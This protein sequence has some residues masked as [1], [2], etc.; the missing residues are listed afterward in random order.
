MAAILGKIEEFDRSKEEWPQYVERLGHFF[1]ANDI[2]SAEKKR[3][4]FLAVVGPTTYR[5]LHN[6]L[7]PAKPGDSSYEELVAKLTKHFNPTPSEAVQRFKFN[8]RVRK[9]GESVSTY[10]SELRS[11][12]E[13]CNYGSSLESMLRDRLMCGIQ[14]EGIQK[15]LMAEPK[16]TYAK[17]LELA[18]GLEA[19]SKSMQELGNSKEPAGESGGTT[20]I[21]H[22]VASGTQGRTN[23][24]R[25]GGANHI[26]STCRHKNTVCNGCGKRGHLK[27]VCRS[28]SKSTAPSRTGR[29]RRTPKPVHRV[30][31]SEEDNELPLFHV[32]ESDKSQ[33][34]RVTVT[35]EQ[36]EIPMEVDTGAALSLVSETTYKEL[37]LDRTL[38]QSS[39]K[40][41]SYSGEAIP[42]LGSFDVKVA[43]KSQVATL[44]LLVVKGDGPSLF[45]RNWLNH[46]RLE[47][48]EIYNFHT[49]S[50]QAT[51]QKHGA[52]FK[53]GLGTLKGFKAKI[54]VE[55]GATPR[56]SKARTVPYSLKEMVD[57]ELDRL[58][59]EG[60]LEP[61]QFSDWASPIVPVLKADKSSIRICGDFKQ[62]INPVSKLDRYPIPKIEDLFASLAGGQSFT[63]IDLSQAYQQLL[64]DDDS[65][66]YV[67]I[68]THRGLFRYTRL[69]FGVSSAP[70]I[71]QRVMESVLQG[72]PGVVVYIDDILVTGPTADKHLETLEQVLAR[73]EN[74]GLRVKQSKCKFMAPSVEY[75]GFKID[76]NG[77]HPLVE[78]VEAVRDAPTPR[79]VQELKAYLG[80]L[81]YYSKFLPNMSSVLTPLYQLLRKDAPWHWTKSQE[82]AFAESKA[83][84]VSSR[85]LVH[86]NPTLPLTLACDASA[87]GVGAVLAHRMPD[88]TERPIGYASRSLTKAERNYSQLEKEGLACIFGIKRFHSYLFGHHFELVTD[89]KPLL[90]L[91]N[92]HR[93]TSPQA[94]SRIRRWSLFLSGYEYTL[95]FRSTTEHG[96]ADALSRLPLKTVDHPSETPPEL[97][98]LMEH[99][100]DSPLTQQ[101]I[102][103]YTRRDPLL[104]QVLQYL[105]SGWPDQSDPKLKPF[106][107]R[108]E[109]L[110]LLD[111][112]ILW[113]SRVVVP[114][115]AT[116]TVLQELHEG[117][118]GMTR[119]KSL[120]RMYVWWPGMDKDIEKSVASCTQ[121][122]LHQV[123]PPVAPLNPWKWPTRPWARLHVDFAGPMQ[124]KMYLVIIDAHSK[125]IE[126]FPTSS[127]TS[128]VVVEVLRS[129]FARFGIPEMIVS[130]NGP[131]FVSEEFE[132]FLQANAV[133]HV[134]SAP[135]HPSTNGLAE[136]A[137]QI[138]KKGLKKVTDGTI[139]SR[140]AKVLM[141]YRITPQSTTGSSPA[142]LLLGRQPR[143]RLDLLKPSPELSVERK[144][145]QQK[146]GHDRKA[147]A[148]VFGTGSLV[149]ARN[150][151][152]GHTWIPGQIVERSGPV[153]FMV[154]CSNG[155][156]VR[157]HQDQLRHRTA[158]CT[159]E[160]VTVQSSPDVWI[161]VSP[162]VNSQAEPD[163]GPDVSSDQSESSSSELLS[164]SSSQ[165]VSSNS[166]E[167]NVKKR[168]PRRERHPPDR[169]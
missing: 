20:T 79:N 82:K 52:V 166:N 107:V 64:L 136:R 35:I 147:K 160:S 57:K 138:L 133:K 49:S 141:S 102:R 111:G 165:R 63:K 5:L 167:M 86:F 22:V 99:L 105:R 13:H 25:C 27:R 56:F 135:Y 53:E 158:T 65:K 122:Q 67:V 134:T 110:S 62:T 83:L 142:E 106:V 101:Q 85:L 76:A 75:L 130:D 89:H 148:R 8:T 128:S 140:L 127:T 15:R 41:Y 87:Y 55:D 69:P 93:P 125:W 12:A 137:V 44:P 162:D 39:K 115:K 73:L 2:E 114:S 7:A 145:V 70:G 144:Q 19:A 37:W 95:K 9:P 100:S 103:L 71:F 14:D 74:A 157:R 42:V 38:E 112:C 1:A 169:F 150:F 59:A 124:G 68:N 121:C 84:L 109:E 88:G 36:Q 45:G 104:A 78:K 29:R 161:D 126:V 50:L 131:C 21:H 30:D 81:T 155:N 132:S 94:S 90:A 3:S 98:L 18:Q 152:S 48:H 31:E 26:A 77:L 96:N 16:L 164:E 151:G 28:K 129:I 120:A 47:W 43:Y 149:Y 60:T 24:Y 6:L 34:L 66:Q 58:V 91:L 72:L 11:L 156:L 154:K 33:P 97:V 113:G 17:A 4:V 119:M 168:Y 46:I 159:N 54:L 146:I 163:A 23:C 32:K 61:T 80:L 108:K 116:A 118:P 139:H 40:L 51:L 10:I 153:S 143:T 123:T 92:E 117:H